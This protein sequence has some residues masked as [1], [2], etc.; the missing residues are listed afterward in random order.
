MAFVVCIP[1]RFGSRRLPGKA[2]VDINGKPLIEHVY[3]RA[4]ESAADRVIIATD[5]IKIRD[6]CDHFGA[7]VCMT[8][9]DHAS[10]TDWIAEAVREIGLAGDDIVI[11]LQGDEPL[12]PPHI[13]DQLA[14]LMNEEK[15][16][17][18]GTVATP[19][20]TLDEYRDPNVVKV[21]L[22]QAGH[23]LYFSRS[24]IPWAK[25]SHT[26]PKNAFRHLGIYAFRV[27]TLKRFVELPR[28]EVEIGESLEQLRALANGM[29]IKVLVIEERPP[30][31]VDTEADLQQ[32]KS[33]LKN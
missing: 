8:S 22:G 16:V 20:Q 30:R 9:K 29:A 17:D 2:L 13:I 26:V 19:M 18:L 33:I 28:A 24:P 12:M 11:N 23:A 32:V 5:D 21:V 14:R 6:A 25:E 10:G 1:A 7:E 27:S 4:K 3:D 31:G 15:N